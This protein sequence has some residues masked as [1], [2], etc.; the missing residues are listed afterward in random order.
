MDILV[1]EKV[2]ETISIESGIGS[3]IIKEKWR[4]G[5]LLANVYYPITGGP[6]KERFRSDN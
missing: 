3:T 4:D 1:D 6:N 2:Y 5:G